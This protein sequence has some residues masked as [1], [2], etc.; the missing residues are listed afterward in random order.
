MISPCSVNELKQT[1]LYNNIYPLAKSVI[2]PSKKARCYSTGDA[3]LGIL[4]VLGANLFR[5]NPRKL[6]ENKADFAEKISS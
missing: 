6:Q 4:M 3:I 2:K 1:L 5:I